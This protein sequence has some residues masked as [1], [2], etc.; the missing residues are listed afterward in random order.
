MPVWTARFFHDANT[1]V[2]S[3]FQGC[4]A[5]V[6]N[7]ETLPFSLKDTLLN[8]TA[9]KVLESR[10]GSE[11]HTLRGPMGICG[12]THSST[13]APPK[14]LCFPRHLLALRLTGTQ[15]GRD[16][17]HKYAEWKINIHG[18]Q[19]HY[20]SRTSKIRMVTILELG[21]EPHASH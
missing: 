18:R 1:Y 20:K 10:N 9:D 17:T 3:T 4:S 13:P 19:L 8:L 2:V 21:K 15:V 12:P 14:G 11:R 5:S 16:I 6:F 7:R